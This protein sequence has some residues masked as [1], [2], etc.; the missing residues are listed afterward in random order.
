[1]CISVSDRVPAE[2]LW[3][4]PP[5]SIS[6]DDLLQ[7][8][9]VDERQLQFSWRGVCAGDCAKA[10]GR[11]AAADINIRL[12][13]TGD[14]KCVES[15]DACPE[16]LFLIG[17]KTFGKR[18]VIILESRA[19]LCSDSGSSKVLTRPAISAAGAICRCRAGAVPVP[20]RVKCRESPMGRRQT[21]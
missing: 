15:V 6:V 2:Y 4:N 19:A 9:L 3:D 17:L 14:V 20:C 11:V 16:S 1:M 18:H 7:L 10:I 21:I 8:E 5:E 12:A 13:V